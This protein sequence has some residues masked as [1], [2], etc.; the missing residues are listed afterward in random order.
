MTLH[1]TELVSKWR[2][3]W[4]YNSMFLLPLV[5]NYMKRHYCLIWKKSEMDKNQVS[6]IYQSGYKDISKEFFAM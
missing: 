5:H 6:D 3:R 2:S 1:W 4:A